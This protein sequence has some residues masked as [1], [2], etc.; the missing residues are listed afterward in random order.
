[1]M[2]HSPVEFNASLQTEIKKLGTVESIVAPTKM[3]DLYLKEWSDAFPEARLWHSPALNIS[4]IESSRVTELKAMKFTD[5]LEAL[6]IEGMPK[7]Q[8]YVFFHSPSRS[9]IVADLIFNV[10]PGRGFQKLLQ[11]LNG[12]YER[13]GPSKFFR[14]FISNEERFKLS[15]IEIMKRDFENVIVGHGNNVMGRGK[16]ALRDAFGLLGPF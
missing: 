5:D 4:G 8:E 10:A 3:H 6:P 1:L 13:T 16:P 2:V 11:R 7:I 14:Q 15:L 12:I 9:L